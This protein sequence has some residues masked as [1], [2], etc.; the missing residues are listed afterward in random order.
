MAIDLSAR[1]EE[2]RSQ[3]LDTTKR[4]RL[5]SLKLGKTGALKLI[6]PSAQS[7]WE[8]LIA[9][10]GTMSF[11]TRQELVG[12]SDAV[13]DDD[14][15]GQYP[16]VFDPDIEG[17]SP[18]GRIDLRTCLESPN[19]LESHVLTDLS[20]KLLKPRLGRLALNAKTSM[21][22]QGVP[23][24][25]LT[26]GMLRWF[27]SPDSQVEILSPLLLVPAELSRENVGSPW[28]LKAQEDEVV[29]NHSLVQLMSS[30]FAIRL[31]DLPNSEEADHTERRDRHFAGVRNAIRHQKKWE[32][33]DDCCLGIFGFQKIAM[34]E[35]LGKNQDQIAE[36]D[37]CRAIG[38]D[39]FVSLYAPQGLPRDR[40]LDTATHPGRTFHILDSD[41]SQHEAIEAAKRGASLIVDGPPGTGKSQTIAN[42][43]AEFLAEGK[44]VL[45]VSE[46][47]AAL[48]VVKRRLDENGLGDFC[49]ECHSHKAN[50]KQVIEE[51]GR[52]LSLP[53]EK[54]KNQEDDLAHLSDTRELL[55][56]YVR[57]LHEIRQPLGLSAYQVHGR[58]V[59]IRG[60]GIS[61][62]PIPDLE[63]LTA[64]RLRKMTD[65]VGR[66]TDFRNVIENYAIHPWRGSR[67]QGR[68]LSLDEDIRHHFERLSV[69]LAEIVE[70]APLLTRLGFLPSEPTMNDWL[71]GT[72]LSRKSPSYP[73][74]PPEW[75][76]GEPREIAAGY[77]RLDGTTRDYRQ[78]R[79]QMPEF[80]DEEILA[81]DQ[82]ETASFPL[83]IE[84]RG[85]TLLPHDGKTLTAL[86]D[87]L[88]VVIDSLRVLSSHLRS[89]DGRLEPHDGRPEPETAPDPGTA[90]GQGGRTP[91]DR[92]TIR[93]DA[94]LVARSSTA[95]RNIA[96]SRLLRGRPTGV[97]RST[98]PRARSRRR[99]AVHGF[100]RN[101]FDDPQVASGDDGTHTPRTS[102]S[103]APLRSRGGALFRG[104]SGVAGQRIG[105]SWFADTSSGGAGIAKAPRTSRPDR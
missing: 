33:L 32:V 67:T 12:E 40:D 104:G 62:C 76:R 6:H 55:N 53:I 78:V 100:P 4:N 81:I 87:H 92:R 35:D 39:G 89:T 99:S 102:P 3:L 41:S 38:G 103:S 24:L 91:G 14:S 20:D 79:Q 34:W 52:C 19:L 69:A 65:L 74:V 5:I 42:I 48:E 27:E 46:K 26:F 61:R 13:S 50:K 75:F 95:A 66:L 54:Y 49:L 56:A 23:T 80:V 71:Q 63:H 90:V 51:L 25:F 98:R 29:P 73:V 28:E 97:P 96:V 21:T 43:I 17:D 30:S 7:L 82:A 2:W 57:S 77:I 44:S 59:A 83:A 58:L 8:Q 101:R 1:I 16:S 22:E 105:D 60:R 9:L 84:E 85:S 68:S 86:K 10:G 72:E 93:S 94:P 31:P 64:D 88:Q 18:T 11:P 70:A 15:P 47:S 36:H 37:L 45:F